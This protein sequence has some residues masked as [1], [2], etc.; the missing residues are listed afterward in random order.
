MSAV[1]RFRVIDTG[2][3]SGCANVA[4]DQA[5]IDLQELMFRGVVECQ[6]PPNDQVRR[7]L[8]HGVGRRLSVL[9]RSIEEIFTLSP[10][11]ARRDSPTMKPCRSKFI[12]M[13]S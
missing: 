7:F 5:M 4:F 10:Q 6:N 12:F 1:P 11:I 8:S 2:L 9:K 3:R 13:R